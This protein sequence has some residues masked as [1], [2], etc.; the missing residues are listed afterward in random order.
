M[1]ST[2]ALTRCTHMSHDEILFSRILA[3]EKGLRERD[4]SFVIKTIIEYSDLLVQS[5]ACPMVVSTGIFETFP[6]IS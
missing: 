3:Q 5:M 6:D 1:H 4:P 2:F